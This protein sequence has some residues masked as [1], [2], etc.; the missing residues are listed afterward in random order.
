MKYI[1]LLSVATAVLHLDAQMVTKQ[2]RKASVTFAPSAALTQVIAPSPHDPSAAGDTPIEIEPHAVDSHTAP[3]QLS[4]MSPSKKQPLALSA[5]TAAQTMTIVAL[6]ADSK[7]AQE[8]ASIII[9]ASVLLK[10]AQQNAQALEQQTREERERN[11][12]HLV[13]SKIAQ[14]YPKFPLH[15]VPVLKEIAYQCQ[16]LSLPKEAHE[17]KFSGLVTANLASIYACIPIINSKNN[18]LSQLRTKYPSF[19]ETDLNAMLPGIL[20]HAIK[21]KMDSI[22]LKVFKAPR[23]SSMLTQDYRDLLELHEQISALSDPKDKLLLEETVDIVLEDVPP[24]ALG[25]TR[26]APVKTDSCII[27]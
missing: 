25:F 21:Q 12:R 7:H 20:K 17:I 6:S 15:L 16:Q 14:L 13:R 8:N 24:S 5:A 27:C 10:L 22:H 19:S 3:K 23:D 2:K 9:P 18:I 11:L 4:P 26:A 1:V